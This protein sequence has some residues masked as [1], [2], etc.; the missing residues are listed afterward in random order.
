VFNSGLLADP[1]GSPVYDYAAAPAISIARAEAMRD[2]CAGHGV[3]LVAAAIQFALRHPLSRRSSSAHAP[4]G[5]RADSAAA[6]CTSPRSCGRSSTRSDARHDRRSR[7]CGDAARRRRS[8]VCAASVRDDEWS[9]RA[10][11]V[12][13]PFDTPSARRPLARVASETFSDQLAAFVTTR[14]MFFIAT[15]DE[16]ARPTA[17]TSGD[18]ARSLVDERTLAFPMYDGNVRPGGECDLPSLT[19]SPP[20]SRVVACDDPAH[21]PHRPS[22]PASPRF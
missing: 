22:A 13:G 11:R 1:D 3:T 16:D 12:P 21:D 8:T 18:P 7:V 17:R 2:A 5:D 4:R 10:T 19:G 6:R 14:D 15:T 9:T 20:W